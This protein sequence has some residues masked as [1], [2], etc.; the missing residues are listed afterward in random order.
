M[1]FKPSSVVF[2]DVMSCHVIWPICVV[3]IFTCDELL[4]FLFWLSSVHGGYSPWSYWSQCTK[5][6]G[7]GT[8]RRSRSCTN[9]LPANGG[10]NCSGQGQA[11]ELQSCN[12]HSCPGE[13]FATS[14][15]ETFR[16]F[17]AI[18]SNHCEML[19]RYSIIPNNRVRQYEPHQH[20]CMPVVPLSCSDGE[21]GK[22][23]FFRNEEDRIILVVTRL[24]RNKTST[25][26]PCPRPGERWWETNVVIPMLI[27][28]SFR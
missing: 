7:S 5:S 11:T 17:N 27:R 6:C 24:R 13:S 20:S 9:P 25:L 18:I 23:C 12:T 28:I 8:Q 10:Q 19:T 26:K 14:F 4:I 21:F 16:L 2:C 22:C 1:P 15:K 3:A